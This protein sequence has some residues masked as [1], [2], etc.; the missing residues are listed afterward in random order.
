MFGQDAHPRMEKT[1]YTIQAPEGVLLP[2]DPSQEPGQIP[3][4]LPPCGYALDPGWQERPG[5]SSRTHSPVKGEGRGG[6]PSTQL[7]GSPHLKGQ[8][9]PQ[10]RQGSGKGS[11]PHLA[12]K[13]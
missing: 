10:P 2:T 13:T 8:C 12:T 5:S 7:V 1:M 11:F 4:G 3:T 9:E 6:N